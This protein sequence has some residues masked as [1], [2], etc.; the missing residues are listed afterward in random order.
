[1]AAVFAL[2]GPETCELRKEAEEA[3]ANRLRKLLK[4]IATQPQLSLRDRCISV[5]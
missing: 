2:Y 4:P 1:M 5:S 3:A